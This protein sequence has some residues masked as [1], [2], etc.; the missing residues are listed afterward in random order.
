[1]TF[2]AKLNTV[3]V[4]VRVLSAACSYPYLGAA[5]QGTDTGMWNETEVLG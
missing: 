5:V 4:L 3:D 2:W 1:M